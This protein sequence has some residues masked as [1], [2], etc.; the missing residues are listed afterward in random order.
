MAVAIDETASLRHQAWG[1]LPICV[2]PLTAVVCRNLMLPWL[3]MWT[4]S[5]AIYLGLKGLTWWRERARILHPGWRSV[6]YLLAWPGMDAAAFLD[7]KQRVPSPAFSTWLWAT[8]KTIAGAILLW[9]VA[10]SSPQDYALLRG[11]AGMLGLILLLH[12]GS[13]QI[14]ALVWQRLGVKAEPIMSA[15]LRSTSLASS[16]GSAGTLVSASLPVR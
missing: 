10:R 11:W 15:P 14:V 5:F 2:L 4:L 3:F 9:V 1:W 7:P 12:F 6:A 16:G 8:L 13:F